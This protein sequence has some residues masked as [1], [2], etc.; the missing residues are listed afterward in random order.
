[1][2]IKLAIALSVL[3]V[4]A[5]GQTVRGVIS[6]VV[7]DPAK[8]AVSSASV[9]VVNEETGEKRAATTDSH[10]GFTVAGL[11]PGRYRVEADGKGFRKYGRILTLE[12]DQEIRLDVELQAGS[13]DFVNV[14]AEPVLI[15]EDSSALGGVI[16]NRLIVGLPLDGRNFYELSL[17]LPGVDPPA[18][19]S[20]G[21]VRGAFTINVN[22][23]R[24]DSNNFLLD[25]AYN[26]DP[27]LNG[28]SVTP[29]VDAIREFELATSTYD[30]SF[31]RNAGGQVNV[32]TRS[33]SNQVHGTAFEFFRNAAMDGTNFFAAAGQPAPAY[34][35]NQFGGTLGG[36]IKKNRTFFFVDYQ[37]T[38][39]AAGEP[40]V[41]NVPTALERVGNFSQSLTP[42]I[43][44]TTGSPL[45]GGILPSYYLNPIGVAIA[46]LYPLPNRSVAGANYVSS[47]SQFDNQNNFDIRVDHAISTKDNLFYRYSFL[48][49]RFFDPFGG[50]GF[51]AV[52]NY[53]LLIPSRSQNTA[54]SETHTF[55]PSLINDVHLGFNRVSNGDYQQNQGVSINRQLGLPELSANSRDW[56]LSL[57]SVN[58]Y[59]P[60]GD[61]Y[62]SP[63]HGTTNTYMVG[64]NATWSHGRH[65]VKFG[66]DS[67]IAQENAYRDVQ[68][69]GFIDFTGELIGNALEELLLGAPTESGG[70]VM[71]NPEHL[72]THSYNF[73]VNDTWRVRPDFTVT[74]GL[75]Y[76]YNSPAVDAHNQ[77]NVYNPATGALV[78]VGVSGFPAGG[79]NP[80]YNNFAPQIGLAWSPGGRGNTVIR[81]G[82]GIHYDQSAL[83]I[84]EGLYFSAPYYNLSVYYPIEGLYNLSLSNPFPNNF[85][86]PYPQSATAF[87]RNLRT[88]Y[89]Q[90]W[91][92]GIQRRLGQS[93]MAEIDYV[94][95]KGTRLIDSRNINQSAPSTN[96]EAL[97]PNPYFADVDI[98]ET[99]ANSIYHSLQ[100]KFD[101]RLSKGLS[102]LVSY[103]YSKSIDDASGFF[104][105]TGDPNF[106]QNSYDLSAERGRSDF[107]IRQRLTLSYAYDLPIARGNR[108]LGGWQSFG[109][110]TFQS[111]QPFTVMLVEDNDN[112]NTGFSN[113]GYGANNRPDV[114]GNPHLSN[115]GA[116]EWFNTN[117]F[118]VAPYGTFGNA[119]RNILSGPGLETIDFSIVKNTRVTERLN[120]Q[121][122]AEFFNLLNHTNFN[123]PDN[124]LGDSTFGQITS[125]QDPRRLQ[126]ALKFLF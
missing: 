112:S 62:T 17:L 28:V 36:P 80:D 89:I 93:R 114:V 101:Q 75:R 8:A 53:G 76:E 67:R 63:E 22:G 40:L 54:L 87:E 14:T 38:R 10:G 34:Q 110:L 105:T 126:L 71:N 42:A 84:S 74:L 72:R 70:A 78:P 61:E 43:D 23:M 121:F 66:F 24:E 59:S 39:L 50:S 125:A 44:P 94:G 86:Y 37:G 16:E 7:T 123:L 79:Y 119:G 9:T 109:V 82:Y 35:R 5:Q 99:N 106:P 18:Q 77:A 96:P 111:G 103:T 57:I 30:T 33:G 52:P 41:T 81:A 56:G 45:P 83:A 107:D 68:A 108:W 85:P 115:P 19:G 55:T 116:Q 11:L 91:N 27:K 47:P 104:S 1:M 32:V 58:G 69:R 102:A 49:D 64:D 124:F 51:S 3:I 118:A 4:A 26:G 20:A 21:S 13:G 120:T 92:F 65:L 100:A 29:Q 6:G 2:K 97:P 46:A 25:G 117:A 12:V 31:G 15:R 88:P 60:L 73:F 90:Q 113:L 98:I 48:D 122:R 95:S